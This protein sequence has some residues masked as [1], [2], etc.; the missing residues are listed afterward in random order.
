[1]AREQEDEEQKA[2][3]EEEQEVIYYLNL[4]HSL[5]LHHHFTSFRSL[6]SSSLSCF[7]LCWDSCQVVTIRVFFNRHFVLIDPLTRC[8]IPCICSY[9][10]FALGLLSCID[11]VVPRSPSQSELG[12]RLPFLG[13]PLIPSSANPFIFYFILKKYLQFWCVYFRIVVPY[14]WFVKLMF[15]SSY[16]VLICYKA[17]KSALW[18]AIGRTVDSEMLRLGSLH[19]SDLNASPQFIGALTELVWGHIGT[20]SSVMLFTLL[21][22]VSWVVKTNFSLYFIF[23]LS[24]CLNPISAST[25]YLSFY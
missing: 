25:S 14:R 23:D 16:P 8:Y 21:Y 15:M 6:F 1:M 20:S 13:I 19:R 12:S 11:F 22:R 17:L 3:A 9:C 24:W 18:Y 5:L 2:T 4:F 7:S 10:R